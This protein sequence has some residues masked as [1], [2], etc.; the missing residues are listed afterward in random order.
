M[1]HT[2]SSCQ[3]GQNKLQ[4]GT[5]QKGSFYVLY[6]SCFGRK[7]LSKNKT[8]GIVCKNIPNISTETQC[9]MTSRLSAVLTTDIHKPCV[10]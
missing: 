5:E 7:E 6:A 2:A 9:C 8:V 1:N 10:T 3:S 4:P